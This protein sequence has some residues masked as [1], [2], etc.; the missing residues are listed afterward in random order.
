MTTEILVFLTAMVPFLELKLAIPLG[1]EFGL[2]R[3]TTFLF[4]VSGTIVPAAISLAL[5]GPTSNFLRKKSERMDKFFEKLFHQ[6][7]KQHSLKFKRYGAI[8]LLAFVAIPLPGSGSVSGTIIAF[9]FDVDYWKALSLI[10]AGTALAGAL[11]LAGFE[12]IFAI[13]NLFA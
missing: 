8:F 9:L 2:S 10:S 12:S 6:T 7:R 3:A 1:L 4:A 11:V 5:I 13:L